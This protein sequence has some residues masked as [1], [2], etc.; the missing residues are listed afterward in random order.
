MT[1][2]LSLISIFQELENLRNISAC[3]TIPKRFSN[4][5][6][7]DDLEPAARARSRSCVLSVASGKAERGRAQASLALLSLTHNLACGAIAHANDVHTMLHLIELA[8]LCVED[9]CHLSIRI[10]DNA[11]NACS[12]CIADNNVG[13]K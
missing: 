4:S 10:H 8:T 5:L 13:S 1:R 6:I 7:L 2:I 3:L 12:T 11:L 9:V